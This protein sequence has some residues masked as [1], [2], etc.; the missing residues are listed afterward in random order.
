MPGKTSTSTKRRPTKKVASKKTKRPT[1]TNKKVKEETLRKKRKT[2]KSPP[3]PEAKSTEGTVTINGVVIEMEQVATLKG[4]L[5]LPKRRRGRPTKEEE[6]LRSKILAEHGITGD[7]RIKRPRGRPRKN[8]TSSILAESL[9][10]QEGT[11]RSAAKSNS[12]HIDSPSIQEKIR[13]LIKLAKEQE[14]KRKKEKKR[15]KEKKKRDKEARKKEK[16]KWR[17]N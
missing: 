7:P 4:I 10:R 15:D 17:K 11:D 16:E 3:P 13:E 8:A 9:P 2:Q 14:K 5:S 6:Q 12:L 1:I